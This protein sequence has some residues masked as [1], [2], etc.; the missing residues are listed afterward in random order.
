MGRV[1]WIFKYAGVCMHFKGKERNFC[2]ETDQGKKTNDWGMGR[3]K[4]FKRKVNEN[5]KVIWGKM[6][7]KLERNSTIILSV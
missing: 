7:E 3:K 5:T 2:E 4:V 1:G 6:K